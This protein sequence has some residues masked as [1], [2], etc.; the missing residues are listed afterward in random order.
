MTSFRSIS[1]PADFRRHFVGKTLR[2]VSCCDYR[3][4]TLCWSVSDSSEIVLDYMIQY[5][6][7]NAINLHPL[8][9]K[10]K[11]YVILYPQ[12]GDRFVTIDSVTSLHLI[13][14]A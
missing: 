14:S 13:Y 9:P 12:N 7:N 8:T 3:L 6:L 10:S 4:N 11:L 5:Y 1:M 2:N